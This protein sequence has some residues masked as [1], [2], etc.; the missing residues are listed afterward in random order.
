MEPDFWHERWA[1][2]QLGF[3]QKDFNQHMQA[4]IDRLEIRPG[5]LIL[6]P[7]CGKS[8]DMLY[9]LNKGYSVT[10][11]EINQLAVES[12]FAENNLSFEVTQLEDA[13]LYSH[14]NLNIYCADFLTIDLVSAQKIDAVYDRGSLIALPP[15]M[16]VAY[17]DR[18]TQMISAGTR[19]MLLTLDYAQ[20]EMSGPPFSVTPEDVE[21]LFGSDYSIEHAYSEDCLALEPHFRDK[22]LTGLD[23]HIFLLQKNSGAS[24][25]HR[26]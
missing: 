6:V 13:L 14:K 25:L 10:G 21:Q 26:N 12:F 22:G 19:S 1:K 24:V 17:V 3:H 16:R 20:D 15:E 9:L 11:I 5:G 2:G 8:L 7:L 18:L 4:F 23:E